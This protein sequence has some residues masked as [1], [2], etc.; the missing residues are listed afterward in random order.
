MKQFVLKGMPKQ[1]P[2]KVKKVDPLLKSAVQKAVRRG[3]EGGVVWAVRRLWAIPDGRR[4]LLWRIPI[5]AAEEV[6]P[7]L[8]VVGSPVIEMGPGLPADEQMNRVI[9]IVQGMGRLPKNKDAGG[10]QGFVG[11]A[12]KTPLIN[13]EPEIPDR[14]VYELAQQTL[15][16]DRRSGWDFLLKQATFEVVTELIRVAAWRYPRGGMRGDPMLLVM[17]AVL[18]IKSP[19]I[20]EANAAVYD[21]TP[22][23]CAEKAPPWYAAD[24]HTGPGGHALTAAA[25][26]A[27]IKPAALSE[28]WFDLESGAV[29]RTAPE[30]L[31]W[32]PLVEFRM[33]SYGFGG[34]EEA[35]KR[36]AE[37]APLV[38]S[39]VEEVVSWPA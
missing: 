20:V 18:A 11:R 27:R 9:G 28:L 2:A 6:W 1:K 10:L 25:A 15:V 16:M 32:E 38:R 4:W 23:L 35:R 26:E 7:A 36:W 31:W 34:I 5:L 8:G 30:S 19:V 22:N 14:G 12:G 33:R 24:M 29:D 13:G 21:A 39:K 17:S 3:S 37:L